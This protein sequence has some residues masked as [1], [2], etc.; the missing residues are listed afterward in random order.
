MS[1]TH[2]PMSPERFDETATSAAS[3]VTETVPELATGRTSSGRA[4]WQLFRVGLLGFV[5]WFVLDARQLMTN[6]MNSPYGTRRSVAIALLR[7]VI[8]VEGPFHVG[9]IVEEA[10]HLLGRDAPLAIAPPPPS[11]TIAT[12]LLA[13]RADPFQN[14]LLGRPIG[15]IATTLTPLPLVTLVPPSP[16]HPLTVLSVGDSLGQDL[17]I[18]L[19][20][21]IGADANV[22]V[23]QL[24]REST[25]L[26]DTRYYNWPDQ[27][28]SELATYHPQIVVMMLGANDWQDFRTGHGAQAYPGT[29]FWR[30]RYAARVA[31]VMAE[32]RLAG[33]HL[34]WVGLP[35]MGPANPFPAAAAP[36][37]NAVYQLEARQHLGTT[38]YSTYRRFMDVTGQFNE[39]LPGPG[40]AYQMIRSADGVHFTDPWGDDLLG[41][42]VAIY[43]SR[44]FH[45]RLHVG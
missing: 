44:H 19:G 25:G 18:G 13:G 11:A 27:I 34:I 16:A 31:K 3:A 12:P 1:S 35:V 20:D 29:S 4:L 9:A 15:S 8:A 2:T 22:R 37:L 24:A 7:P 43:I 42:D 30:T 32:V 14:A 26:A 28:A 38:Y 39:Y 5:L 33:A 6:A 17:G 10:D 41:H 23:V 45:L 21:V 40:G 36:T